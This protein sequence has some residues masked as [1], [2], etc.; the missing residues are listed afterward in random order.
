MGGGLESRCVGRV[1]GVDGVVQGSIRTIH[2][3]LSLF[4]PSNFF[5]YLCSSVVHFLLLIMSLYTL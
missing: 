1:D 5:C 2:T 4:V 3:T